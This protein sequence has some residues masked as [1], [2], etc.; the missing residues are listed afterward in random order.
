MPTI[1]TTLALSTA[2]IGHNSGNADASDAPKGKV[3]SDNLTEENLRKVRDLTAAGVRNKHDTVAAIKVALGANPSGKAIAAVRMVFCVAHIVAN[4]KV[5]SP[6]MTVNGRNKWAGIAYSDGKA[7][8]ADKAMVQAY[9]AAKSAWSLRLADIGLG[10]AKTTKAKNDAAQAKR[11]TP[12]GRQDTSDIDQAG[13]P[14]PPAKAKT[15]ADAVAH[16]TQQANLLQ[17]FCNKNAGVVPG[18]LAE[19]VSKLYT[20]C[21]VASAPKA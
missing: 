9:N 15:A 5:T 8:A 6:D 4:A 21:T 13:A 17:M 7:R 3:W 10:A 20:A 12:D 18:T 1:K 16:I 14:T 2:T 19:I 11:G